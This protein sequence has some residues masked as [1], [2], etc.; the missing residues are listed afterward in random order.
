MSNVPGVFGE[1]V[2]GGGGGGYICLPRCTEKKNYSRSAGL[3]SLL[4]FSVHTRCT[5]PLELGPKLPMSNTFSLV[6][7]QSFKV[8][9][10]DR[11]M[12]GC[13]VIFYTNYA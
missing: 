2:G 4:H 6:P 1:G 13:Y 8:K 3:T 5:G 9:L 10:F 12:R 11:D 7:S